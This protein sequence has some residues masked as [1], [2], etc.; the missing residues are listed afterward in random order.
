MTGNEKARIGDPEKPNTWEH[1]TIYRS[2]NPLDTTEA[3]NAKAEYTKL[4]SDWSAAVETFA[5]RIRRSSTSAWEG[6]AAAASQNAIANYATRALEL[7]PAL[8]ALSQQVTTTVNGVNNTR[9]GVDEPQNRPD[10]MWNLDG[11]DFIFAEPGSRSMT[12]INKARD[13]AREAMQ[14]NYVKDFVAADGQIPVLPQPESPTSPLTTWKPTGGTSTEDGGDDGN[15]NGTKPTDSNSEQPTSEDPATNEDPATTEDPTATD[16]SVDEDTTEGTSPSST[17][18]PGSTSPASAQ[19]TTPAGVTPSG[20]PGAGSPG[21]GSPGSSSG[22]AGASSGG[23]PGAVTP[24]SPTAA[25]KAPTGTTAAPGGS[26]TGRAGAPGMSGMG[27]GRG[28][29]KSEDD[30]THQI[31]D[32]LKN[33]ENTEELLGETPRVIQ[34]GVIGGTVDE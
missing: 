3:S 31:P 11:Y 10:S 30:E 17:E 34:G 29:G 14:N 21:G 7:T 19:T 13:E 33:M 2:F 25:G 16:D 26:S 28:G 27:G 4:A 32:W 24:G 8:N 20:A 1:W 6:A 23:T 15:G 18:E 12:A 9:K 22:G 5:A